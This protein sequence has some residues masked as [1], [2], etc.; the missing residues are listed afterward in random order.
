MI[1]PKMRKKYELPLFAK[2]PGIHF[3]IDIL[4]SELE[5]LDNEWKDVY[6]ANRGLCANHPELAQDN[7]A[8]FEQI[9][10][11]QCEADDIKASLQSAKLQC[12]SMVSTMKEQY[13][14]LKAYKLKSKRHKAISPLLDEHNWHQPTDYYH[15][16]PIKKMIEEQFS[17]KAI[18]VRI[19]KLKAGATLSPHIDYDPTYA[20]R[21]IVPIITSSE[22]MNVFWKRHEKYE[23]HL[24]ADGSAYFLNV[25]FKH[26]VV[27]L[28]STDRISLM[29][30]LAGQKDIGAIV[31]E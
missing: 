15:S 7:H 22:I 20:V 12:D 4:K 8:N 10:L 29:F 11:T 24:P 9:G 18:R 21:I 19:V 27:N 2:L 3:D 26:S 30:S 31:N 17:E 28:T 25:G 5:A 23:F 6:E 1:I 14:P 16:S 13:S